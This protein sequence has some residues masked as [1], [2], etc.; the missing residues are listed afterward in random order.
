MVFGNIKAI[1]VK[2]MRKIKAAEILRDAEL[3]N[4]LDP[5]R[6][7]DL[8]FGV[9]RNRV[10]YAVCDAYPIKMDSGKLDA[11]TMGDNENA[12]NFIQ[13]F[14][15]RWREEPTAWNLNKTNQGLL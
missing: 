11:M 4:M 8:A 12:L 15:N 2:V 7:D 5:K 9:Y 14:Q 10:W 3:K 6:D 1:L 13:N